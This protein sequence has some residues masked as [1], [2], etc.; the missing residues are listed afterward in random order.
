MSLRASENER[1]NLCFLRYFV[2]KILLLLAK[3]KSDKNGKM[4][5]KQYCLKNMPRLHT[6]KEQTMQKPQKLPKPQNPPKSS[7]NTAYI[8]IQTT[9]TTKK[10]AIKI[11]K[12]LLKKRLCA[13]IQIRKITSLYQWQEHICKDKE[14]LLQIKAHKKHFDALAFYINKIHSYN[15]PQIIALPIESISEPYQ[16]WLD[17]CTK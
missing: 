3:T 7:K 2:F 4:P 5:K 1:G 14:Y 17:S 13:C 16:K 9:T 12:Y 10:E 6:K 8:A 11:A 15:I